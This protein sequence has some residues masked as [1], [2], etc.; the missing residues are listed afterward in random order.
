MDNKKKQQ[1]SVERFD[2]L[3]RVTLEIALTDEQEAIYRQMLINCH[4]Q[5]KNEIIDAHLEGMKAVIESRICKID[6]QVDNLT[7]NEN[8]IVEDPRKI[9]KKYFNR[10]FSRKVVVWVRKRIYH[11]L[12]NIN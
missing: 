1:T 12:R 8:Y 7:K 11:D 3:L 10:I 4:S 6:L 2:Y 5:N 9:S